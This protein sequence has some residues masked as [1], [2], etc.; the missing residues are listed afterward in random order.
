MRRVLKWPSFLKR[1]VHVR[2]LTSFDHTS[3]LWMSRSNYRAIS[4]SFSPNGCWKWS[5]VLKRLLIFVG[6]LKVEKTFSSLG[7]G[8]KKIDRI[9]HILVKNGTKIQ[10]GNFHPQIIVA[11]TKNLVPVTIVW[12]KVTILYY[13]AI[14]LPEYG[15]FYQSFLPW[16]KFG[17]KLPYWIIVPFFYQ[18]MVNSINLFSPRFLSVDDEYLGESYHTGL[19]WHFFTRIW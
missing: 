3:I 14:F 9:D 18:K 16:Q 17:W 19:W 13:C 4:S 15:K 2:H 8:K 5:K 10:Y 6:N 7:H 1:H 12:A 11:V